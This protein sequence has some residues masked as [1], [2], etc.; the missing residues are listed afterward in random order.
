MVLFDD[1]FVWRKTEK[2]KKISK[3]QGKIKQKIS[4]S[5][6]LDCAFR[7]ITYEGARFLTLTLETW[8]MGRCYP[9]FCAVKW[10]KS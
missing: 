1:N 4:I 3:Q 8:T 9:R 5:K 6:R 10:R 2:N 7:F